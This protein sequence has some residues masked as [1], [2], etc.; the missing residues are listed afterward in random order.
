MDFPTKQM[1]NFMLLRTAWD[2]ELEEW[3]FSVVDVCGV[4]TEQN[5]QGFKQSAKVAK[6]GGQRITLCPSH[7]HSVTH[8]IVNGHKHL[9]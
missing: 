9:K 1:N 7:C 4:L 6:G 8:Y 2:D 5:P 3:F